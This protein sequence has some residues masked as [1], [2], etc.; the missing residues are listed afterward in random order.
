VHVAPSPVN[1]ISPST[2]EEERALPPQ[3]GDTKPLGFQEPIGPLQT[4]A[5]NKN[6]KRGERR[7]GEGAALIRGGSDLDKGIDHEEP[8]ETESILKSQLLLGDG[9]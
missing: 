2:H 8:G 1:E 4:N 9:E 6:R 7:K 5:P 3:P